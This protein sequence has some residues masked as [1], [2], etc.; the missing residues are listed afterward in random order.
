[1]LSAKPLNDP[2]FLGAG[3]A[4]APGG[5]SAAP[6]AGCAALR[7]QGFDANED[8]FFGRIHAI[9]LPTISQPGHML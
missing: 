2:A 1:M 4:T 8:L 5:G 7:K 9:G 3:A 6:N